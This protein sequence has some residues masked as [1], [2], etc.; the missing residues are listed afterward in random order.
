MT[1]R[2]QDKTVLITGGSL[3]VGR[4]CAEAFYAE[5]ANVVIAARR[6][7]PLDEAA[8]AMGSAAVPPE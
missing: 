1:L 6:Q 8:A 4:A 2:F 5:G 7:G 3:G